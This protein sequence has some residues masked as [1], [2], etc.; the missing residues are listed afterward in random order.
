MGIGSC[1]EMS[2]GN[3]PVKDRGKNNRYT[4][5]RKLYTKSEKRDFPKEGKY[6]IMLEDM[7]AFKATDFDIVT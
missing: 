6:Y 2:N 3:L 1:E 5:Y 4:L 7:C